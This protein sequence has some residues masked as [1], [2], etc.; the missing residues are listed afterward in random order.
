MIPTYLYFASLYFY[1]P[2][3]IFSR[4][5]I[6]PFSLL[7]FSGVR[8]HRRV[9]FSFLSSF[10]RFKRTNARTSLSSPLFCLFACFSRFFVR[11]F[12]YLFIFRDF[13]RMIETMPR[14]FPFCCYPV[15]L[16][17]FFCCKVITIWIHTSVSVGV[18]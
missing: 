7:I 6:F 17:F 12:V 18:S 4:L 9:F 1:F 16:V 3:R 8:T 11:L 13:F 10:L 15:E 2:H 5:S 14:F